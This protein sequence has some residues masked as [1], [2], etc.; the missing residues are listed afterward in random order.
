[1][2]RPVAGRHADP[3]PLRGA[4]ETS[5][6]DAMPF[7]AADG[8]YL[9]FQRNYDIHVSFRG[10]DGTW[11]APVRLP[12]GVNTKDVELCPVVSPDGRYLFFMRSGRVFWVDAAVIYDLRPGANP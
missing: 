5:D 3:V 4:F 9:L 2:S 10:R 7:V 6:R 12:S 1:M 8:S 11:L